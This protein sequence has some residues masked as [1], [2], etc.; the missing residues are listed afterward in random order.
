MKKITQYIKNSYNELVY[1]VSWP[2][3][4]ELTNSAV[5]VLI[6]SLIMAAVVFIVDTGFEQALKYFYFKL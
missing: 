1:K 6:A 4:P 2:T 3:L 5:V